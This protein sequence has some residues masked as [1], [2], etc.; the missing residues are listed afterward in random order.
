MVGRILK[1]KMFFFILGIILASTTAFAVSTIIEDSSE[2]TFNN[3]GTTL[4][5]TTV[6]DALIELNNK[7]GNGAY[8]EEIITIPYSITVGAGGNDNSNHAQYHYN[9]GQNTGTGSLKISKYGDK[10][11][12]YIANSKTQ[13]YSSSGRS[14][15]TYYVHGDTQM[16]LSDPTYDT[17]TK[18]ITIPITISIGLGG[19]D[20]SNH[21][22]YHFNMANT[23]YNI[24]LELTENNNSYVL[25]TSSFGTYSSGANT[26]SGYYIHGDMAV[27]FSN[28]L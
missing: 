17:S 14:V 4:T 6:E 19:N 2:I 24:T 18:K 8:N 13:I 21:A 9:F 10:V 5:S 25:T 23:S 28:P 1:S 15:G 12:A 11:I 26:F 16:T 27:T 22:S 7:V 20:N 3:T